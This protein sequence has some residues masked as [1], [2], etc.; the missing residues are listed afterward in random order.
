MYLYHMMLL[1]YIILIT[2]SNI[3]IFN[4]ETILPIFKMHKDS[5]AL[6]FYQME[7][8]TGNNILHIK[9]CHVNTQI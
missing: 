3:E 4:F 2:Y 1:S 9:I 5:V 6:K 8:V 7:E